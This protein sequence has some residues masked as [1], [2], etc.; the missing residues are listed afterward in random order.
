V[1]KLE[2]KCSFC[3]VAESK[4]TVVIEGI[5]INI[6]EECF[7]N[8]NG[9]FANF[10]Q[11]RDD[12]LLFK[13]HIIKE[14]LDKYVIGQEEAKKK[15]AV[16]VY[17]HYKRLNS[18][19]N[20]KKTNIFMTGATGSGKTYLIQNLAK[21]LNVP[22]TI[23][24]ATVFTESG[25]VGKNVEEILESLLKKAEGNIKK[26]EKGIV[27]LDEVDKLSKGISNNTSIN[28][29]NPSRDGVQQAL[30]KI[31]EDSEIEISYKNKNVLI[32]T[33]NILFIA[34]GAF[35]GLNKIVEKRTKKDKKTIG[36]NQLNLKENKKNKENKILTE[37]IVK[38]G[39]I[40]EL[41]GRFPIIVSLE[42]LT[43]EDLKRILI[44]PNDNLISEYKQL[45]KID[46]VDLTVKEDALEYIA[47]EAILK[48]LGAR[49]LRG[50]LE[51]GLYKIM[52]DIPKGN[53][54]EVIVDKKMI[55]ELQ[56]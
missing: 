29:I 6:C 34:G 18:N 31:V 13:P 27:Y 16:S 49:G 50:I 47:K 44:E 56:K 42:T 36:F 28:G 17:N 35:V 26:A 53:I 4:N 43:K 46:N 33:K 1:I 2:L 10:N 37:D 15:I 32:N 54:K 38:F 19:V 14:K 7:K 40:P 9:T 39:I 55:L 25:Y 3:G 20:I 23:V 30:L 52:Y 51:E 41:A 8:L 12:F 22:L 45:F 21:I 24:D 5:N 48:N 11:K